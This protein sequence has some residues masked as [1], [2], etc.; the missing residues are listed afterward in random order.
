MV[1]GGGGVNVGEEEEVEVE[2]GPFKLAKEFIL[3]SAPLLLFLFLLPLLLLVKLAIV[4][5][6]LIK[7]PS[8]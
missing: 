3:E 8:A 5:P 7:S 1:V 2:R 6:L 4:G